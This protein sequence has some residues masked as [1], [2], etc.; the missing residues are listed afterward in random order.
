MRPYQTGHKPRLSSLTATDLTFV[1]ISDHLCQMTFRLEKEGTYI[2]EVSTL[3]ALRVPGREFILR[4]EEEANR[5]MVEL[6][7]TP[8]YVGINIG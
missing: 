8:N 6:G 2:G 4:L 1:T 5:L 7:A 3:P